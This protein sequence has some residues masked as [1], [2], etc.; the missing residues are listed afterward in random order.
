MASV[1]SEPAGGRLS[2]KLTKPDEGLLLEP[3]P[4]P[5]LPVPL[6]PEFVLPLLLPPLLVLPLFVLPPFELPGV[7]PPGVLVLGA[8]LVVVPLLL[9]LPLL[10][11]PLS[12]P[13]A[14][15]AINTNTEIPAVLRIPLIHRLRKF[16]GH[17]KIPREI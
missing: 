14:D 3:V 6:L 16:V 11:A 9:V 2:A 17:T 13:Q 15:S 4:E 7:L 1:P 8:V 5:V 12:P 10:P